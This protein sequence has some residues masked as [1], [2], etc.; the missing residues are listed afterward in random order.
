MCLIECLC[1]TP[2]RFSCSTS[3]GKGFDLPTR[4]AQMASAGYGGVVACVPQ[5]DSLPLEG[6]CGKHAE[7]LPARTKMSS[8][9]D[10]EELAEEL[11]PNRSLQRFQEDAKSILK[12]YFVSLAL[13]D[14]VVSV[15]EL[16]ASCPSEADELG[17][18]AMK[19]ADTSRAVV[20]LFDALSRSNVLDRSALIRSFEK[21]FCTLED[22]KI[23]C[24]HAEKGVLEIIQGC[25]EA[26]CVE[27]KLLTKLPETLLRAG[28]QDQV[29]SG[30]EVRS[31][32]CSWRDDGPTCSWS[33]VR[34]SKAKLAGRHG[35]CH[36]AYEALHWRH[37]SKHHDEAAS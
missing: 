33:S 6:G 22:L 14:T 32:T 24:P 2:G 19:I 34:C 11:P 26:G 15:Q 9:G 29:P 18:V 13:D 17:V 1:H 31:V 23:D 12:E 37:H 30:G 35:P 27:T 7:L 20:T 28:V 3:F 10:D 25:M 36:P 8:F 5:H 4:P 16:L 21:I